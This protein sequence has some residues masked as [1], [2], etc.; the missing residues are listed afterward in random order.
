MWLTDRL[1]EGNPISEFSFASRTVNDMLTCCERHSRPKFSQKSP[2]TWAI[3]KTRKRIGV[4]LASTRSKRNT[5]RSWKSEFER[6]FPLRQR[7]ASSWKS[8]FGSIQFTSKIGIQVLEPDTDAHSHK[9]SV[10]SIFKPKLASQVLQEKMSR[11]NADVLDT[12]CRCDDWGHAANCSDSRSAKVSTYGPD[13]DSQ[14]GLEYIEVRPRAD[15]SSSPDAMMQT[16]SRQPLSRQVRCCRISSRQQTER[17]RTRAA[18]K[19]H[20]TRHKARSTR[21]P[22]SVERLCAQEQVKRK[23]HAT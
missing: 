13:D 10:I 23:P 4:C 7:T 3:C 8:E 18:R 9:E 1:G 20:Q 2:W 14:Q 16:S 6:W 19:F 21:R 17:E 15:R 22:H 12:S 11:W 5:T